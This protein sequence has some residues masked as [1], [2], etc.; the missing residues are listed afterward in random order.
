MDGY[1][2]IYGFQQAQYKLSG[3]KIRDD[4]KND[5]IANAILAAGSKRMMEKY[6]LS[7]AQMLEIVKKTFIKFRS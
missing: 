6:N 3:L 5:W 2:I 4:E 1:P 7:E